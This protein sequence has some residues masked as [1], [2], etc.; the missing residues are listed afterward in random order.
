MKPNNAR[1]VLVGDPKVDSNRLIEML[2]AYY[3]IAD[4]RTVSSQVSLGQKNTVVSDRESK[5]Y[6]VLQAHLIEILSSSKNVDSGFNAFAVDDNVDLENALRDRT[7]KR[8]FCTG[9]TSFLDIQP[10]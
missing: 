9:P 5:K 1:F 7:I 4:S 6:L 2:N 8:F 3:G 10:K